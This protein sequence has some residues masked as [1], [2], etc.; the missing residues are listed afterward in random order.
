MEHITNNPDLRHLNKKNDGTYILKSG[1]ASKRRKI[2]ERYRTKF[3]RYR[4]LY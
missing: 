3:V 1:A 4:T 2:F